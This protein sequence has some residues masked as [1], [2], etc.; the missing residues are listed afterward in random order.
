MLIAIPKHV[1]RVARSR[2]YLLPNKT[3]VDSRN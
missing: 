2:M 1:T 3:F